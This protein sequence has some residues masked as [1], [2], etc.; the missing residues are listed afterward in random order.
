MAFRIDDT[1]AFSIIGKPL[2]YV[3]EVGDQGAASAKDCG[4]F[5]LC[6]IKLVVT[7]PKHGTKLG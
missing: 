4:V 6:L 1:R 7:W 3:T 5:C 2:F